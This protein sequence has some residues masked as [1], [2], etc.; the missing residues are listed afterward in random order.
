MELHSG[1]LWKRYEGAGRG[2]DESLGALDIQFQLRADDPVL[3]RVADT[4]ELAVVLG[5]R[6][7]ILPN[8]FAQAHDFIA[9]CRP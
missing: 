4:G 8:S 7:M 9:A 3:A 6:R 2:D 1:K 5:R